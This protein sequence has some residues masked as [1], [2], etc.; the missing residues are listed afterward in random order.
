MHEDSVFI[1]TLMSWGKARP[2]GEKGNQSL[3]F[4]TAVILR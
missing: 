2:N 4:L 1:G 3:P